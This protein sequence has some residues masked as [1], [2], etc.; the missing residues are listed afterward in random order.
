[1]EPAAGGREIDQDGTTIAR[2]RLPCDVTLALQR[3][4]DATGRTLVQIQFRGE[5]V[6]RPWTSLDQRFKRVALGDG[7][8]MAA[9]PVSIPEL[10]DTHQVRQGG[11]Q[12]RGFFLRGCSPF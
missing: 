5:L 1:M 9:D 12:S 11:V 8:V 4:H 3:G 6:E 7:D 2:M 10:I